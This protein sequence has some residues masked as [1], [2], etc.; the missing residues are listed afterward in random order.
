LLDTLLP[1]LSLLRTSFA[2][3]RSLSSRLLVSPR[4]GILIYLSAR[5]SLSLLRIS[6]RLPLGHSLPAPILFLRL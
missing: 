6:L 1:L 2:L 3:W 5:L 4:R